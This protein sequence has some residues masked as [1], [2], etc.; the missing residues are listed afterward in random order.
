MDLF[1]A[2]R[3]ANVSYTDE[4]IPTLSYNNSDSLEHNIVISTTAKYYE[5]NTYIDWS[6]ESLIVPSTSSFTS[7]KWFTLIVSSIIV[8]YTAAFIDLSSV[9]LNDLRKGVCFSKV[10]TWSLLNPYSTCPAGKWHDWSVILFNAKGSVSNW[11]VNFPIY[12]L[13]AFCWITLAAYITIHKDPLIKQSGIPEIKL[14][15]SG[16]NYRINYYLGLQTLFY[17]TVGLIL[18]VSSGLWLG[19]EGPLVHVSCCILNILYGLLVNT[20]FENEAV[21]RELL[22]AA[23]AT[24]IAVAFS[25]PIGGVL[26][27]LESMATFFTPTKIMWNSFITASV[28]VIFLTGFRVFTDGSNFQEKDLFSVEFGNFSWLFLEIIPFITLGALGGIY[29]YLFITVNSYFDKSGVRHV[30]QNRLLSLVGASGV[31]A[32]QYLE[33]FA[34]LLVTSILTFPIDETKLQL[35]TFLTNLFTAC[36]TDTDTS[37]AITF[38]CSSSN[39]IT[40]LKLSYILIQ[41]FILSTYSFGVNLPG[42]IL[43]PSLVLGATSGR[44]LGLITQAIQTKFLSSEFLATCTESSCIVSPA[45]YA[46]IGAAAFMTGVTKLTMCV[47]V[48]MFELTGAVSYVLPIMLAVMISKFVNDVLCTSNIYDTFLKNNFNQSEQNTYGYPNEGKGAGLVNFTSLTSTVKDKLPDITVK[49]IMV[50]LNRTKCLCLV[51][52]THYTVN[53]LIEFTNGDTHE[54]YPLILK[55]GNPLYLG[56]VNKHEL[57]SKISNIDDRNAVISFQVDGLSRVAISQQLHYERSIGS[58]LQQIDIPVERS[59]IIFNELTSAVLVLETFEK[60]HVNY[61]VI[62]DSNNRNGQT[63]AGFVDRFV[64]AHL[65]DSQ[66]KD[67]EDELVGVEAASEFDIEN[68]LE[69]E[70]LLDARRKRLSIELIT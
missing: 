39:G 22:S 40:I 8:G 28:A 14:I 63:M 27:V 10:D 36:P 60:M 67:L 11:L 25:S 47:V 58:V 69:D 12:T 41:G 9:W 18:V 13:F 31:K 65:I 61:F 29:G 46:V 68:N 59:M 35:N 26:F 55:Y 62:L 50:P 64:I 32:G 17:K 34:V 16:F 24:G 45:S 52:E 37:E 33:V 53:S 51:P 57:F 38:I 1:A 7:R 66:F 20:S 56:Y 44:L 15:I 23:T 19:K 42:G 4:D 21:R 5:N 48:I 2:G 6:R 3:G 43:M 30:I 70:T 49:S 54:G